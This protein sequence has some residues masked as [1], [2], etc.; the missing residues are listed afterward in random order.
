M[1]LACHGDPERED[2]QARSGNFHPL[3]KHSDDP[4]LGGSFA[5]DQVQGRLL[6]FHHRRAVS[7]PSHSVF[8][9]ELCTAA[10]E[11]EKSGWLSGAKDLVTQTPARDFSTPGHRSPPLGDVTDRSPPLGDVTDRSAPPGGSSDGFPVWLETIRSRRRQ[12]QQYLRHG[13]G[14]VSVSGQG[15][16][17][18]ESYLGPVTAAPDW[19]V[20]ALESGLSLSLSPAA[21]TP[22][23]G[24]TRAG[25][26]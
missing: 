12:L 21:D 5:I 3:V 10:P 23:G 22:G 4:W 18:R 11:V 20:S 17:L 25:S 16:A 13:A 15:G 19:L 24:Q 1:P 9:Q 6:K 14:S 2:A 8:R 26:D 7:S